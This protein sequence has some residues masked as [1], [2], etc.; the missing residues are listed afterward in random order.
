VL[1]N[2]FALMTETG[3]ENFCVHLNF[4]SFRLPKGVEQQ[5]PGIY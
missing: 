4:M 2:I 5:R 3:F 1:A